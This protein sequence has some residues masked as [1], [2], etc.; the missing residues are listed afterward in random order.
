M[1]RSSNREQV[2]EW[3]NGYRWRGAE[4]VYNPYDVLLLLD[5]REFKAQW[6]ET[7]TPAFLLNPCSSAA[8]RRTNR[9][10]RHPQ[11][12]RCSPG[13]RGGTS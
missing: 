11:H 2:R 6:F 12:H 10:A 5:Y 1:R 9:A 4:K 3:Y 7:G 13:S 8:C